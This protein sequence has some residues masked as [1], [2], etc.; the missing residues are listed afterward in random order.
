MA[1]MLSTPNI[2][3]RSN[4]STGFQPVHTYR[5]T[6]AA[7]VCRCDG[8]RAIRCG[9]ETPSHRRCS[10]GVLADELCA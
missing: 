3:R 7:C 6:D 5:G 9:G 10:V 8:V 1:T 2:A 4:R